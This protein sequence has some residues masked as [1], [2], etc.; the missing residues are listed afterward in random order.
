MDCEDESRRIYGKK[1]FKTYVTFASPTLFSDNGTKIGLLFY[2][3]DIFHRFI[4]SYIWGEL[5]RP[6]R[7]PI[8][9]SFMQPFACPLFHRI[10]SLSITFHLF[11]SIK[12]QAGWA[13]RLQSSLNHTR[14]HRSHLFLASFSQ[15]APPPFRTPH[16][17]SSVCRMNWF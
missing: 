13:F 3:I 8:I 9:S 4:L 15:R 12:L 2:F 6:V 10:P 17:T 14:Y 16:N 5:Y 11:P 1:L 7:S